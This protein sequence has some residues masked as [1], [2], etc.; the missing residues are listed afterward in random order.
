MRQKTLL[1]G[2][3]AAAAAFSLAFS[4]GG[5]EKFCWEENFRNYV[6]FPPGATR[7]Y[8][9]IQLRNDPIWANAAQLNIHPQPTE[10][11]VDFVVYE[12]GI[13]VPDL[14]D[15]T[16]SFSYFLAN[17]K[18]PVAA[19]EEIRDAKGNVKQNA[20]PAVPGEAKSFLILVNKTKVTIASD[21]VSVGGKTAAVPFV[22]PRMWE[23]GAIRVRDGKLT[24][25]MGH[26]R[27]L[28]EMLSVPF[29]EAVSSFNFAGRSD[30][31]FA[32]TDLKIEEQGEL[33]SFPASR[34]FADFRSLNRKLEGATTETV[35]LVPAPGERRGVQIVLN[36]TAAK[37]KKPLIMEMTWS[38]G[39]TTKYPIT[40]GSVFETVPRALGGVIPAKTKLELAD[41]VITVIPRQVVQYVRP[42][43][44]RFRS[45]GNFKPQYQD[46]IRDWNTLPAASKHILDLE[47][48]LQEDGE[49][50][51]YCDGSYAGSL[52]KTAVGD[53]LKAARKRY[54]ETWNKWAKS[55]S[56]GDPEL[57][58]RLRA[59]FEA[60]DQA[61]KDLPLAV[62]QKVDFI[63]NGVA[64]LKLK[65]NVKSD[66]RFYT[67][68][69]AANPR[70][71]AFADAT[72]SSLKAGRQIIGGVPYAVADPLD[73]AD[74]A[75]CHEAQGASGLTGDEYLGR[76]PA[77]NFPGAVHF[78]VPAALYHKAHVIFALDPDPAKDVVL[79]AKIA[80]FYQDSGVGSNMLADTTIEVE[81]GRIPDSFKQVGTIM[82]KGRKLPLY[83]TTIPLNVGKISDAAARKPHLDIDFY[84]K[85]FEHH[86]QWNLSVKPD[87][88]SRSAFNIFAV[89][90]EKMPVLL[91]FKQAS[92]GN[93]FT[94]DEKAVTTVTLKAVAPAAKGKVIWTAKGTDGKVQFKGSRDYSL[95]K[96]GDTTEFTIDLKAPV[97]FYELDVEVT[98][99]NDMSILHP[100]RF[101]ILGKNTRITTKQ[102]SPYGTWWFFKTHGS[103]DDYELG[104]PL[105]KKAGIRKST[106]APTKEVSEKYDFLCGKTSSTPSIR[107]FNAETGKFN[108]VE[109]MQPD[110]A[111]PKKKIKVKLTGEEWFVRKMKKDMKD[112]WGHYTYVMIWHE[113]APHCGIPEELLNMPLS[114]KSIE[115]KEA[116]KIFVAYLKECRR[117]IK[118]HFPTLRLQIGNSS[119]STGALVRP[120]R[121]GADI[122]WYDSIGIETP[123]QTIPP[124][125]LSEV[126]LQGM[127]ITQDAAKALGKTDGKLKLDGCWEFV[128]RSEHTIGEQKLAEWYMRDTLISLA[129]DFTLIGPG[130]FFDCTNAYY[131][132]VW[133]GSGIVQRAP[134]VYPKRPYV[135]YAALTKVLDGA[136][137]VRQIPTGSTTVYALEFKIKNGKTVTA[138]WAARGNVD[139]AVVNP[140][141]KALITEL[142]GTESNADG[143]EITVKSGTAATYVTTEKPLESVKITGRSFPEEEARAA[144]GTIAGAF[145]DVEKVTVAPDPDFTTH[146][147][148]FLPILK[149]AE[150]TAATVNDPEK[151]KALALTLTADDKYKSKYI[152][153]FTTVMLKDPIAIKGEPE[154]VGLWVKGNSNWGQIRF[155][156]QDA[157]GEIFKNLSTG[158]CW[159]CDIMD[160]PGEL[161]VNF[162]GWSFVS[163]ALVKTNLFTTTSPG[164]VSD[165]WV[166]SGG[167]KKIDFPVKVL[168]VTVG[169]NRQ[170]LD[171]LDFKASDPTLLIQGVAGVEE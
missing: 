161:A 42:M 157:E 81:N 162:D 77:D 142:Y 3:G 168:G 110:P 13:A 147:T 144:K 34:L 160:W 53:A 68:D 54:N 2:I 14:K 82:L 140:S 63:G 159:G 152:T 61:I 78:R 94:E 151:G 50:H 154:A 80:N 124:E 108:D 15:V 45:Y 46:L 103:P 93:V 7:Q 25:Y 51:F 12:K 163:A 156:I 72:A 58:K 138:F 56:A 31:G 126:G 134:Y 71:K 119:S 60:A 79:T 5:A 19:K 33:R 64:Q 166:S 136:K 35:S 90:L 10:K 112:D 86:Q 107:H 30:N 123:S 24:V 62:L 4:C 48:A 22:S 122:N 83:S 21:S 117:I 16:F 104:G 129:N 120:V 17:S 145:D 128:Y 169:V 100:A 96:T 69:L 38:D 36:E 125:R 99:A 41:G 44:R 23:E 105:L 102:E 167:N 155:I 97:G 153:E 18:A 115:Q 66:P 111:D 171:L 11:A 116:D 92:P 149:P 146:H 132:G 76:K 89:T 143:R 8:D 148:N 9:F 137:F 47:I 109:E 88:Y 133:G 40:A 98:A 20:A 67:L 164:P 6:D 101:A 32:V 95:A 74:I 73:S 158:K 65:E 70:A 75:I 106:H 165:Q 29:T 52:R 49:I 55:R 57:T 28:R 59:E 91:D 85:P 84:G 130:L 135:A 139:L 43:P 26:N 114:Q 170:K 27:E 87:P 150:F 131:N 118:K 121:A 39:Q 141:G 1:C 37:E 113:S 127:R